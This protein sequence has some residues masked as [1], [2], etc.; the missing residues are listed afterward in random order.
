V[1]GSQPVS[2]VFGKEARV[3]AT[4][5]TNGDGPAAE[6]DD[7]DPVRVACLFTFVVVVASMDR[8]DS[9]GGHR[10]VRLLV[11]RVYHRAGL[12]GKSCTSVHRTPARSSG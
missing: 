10:V 12:S 2:G 7:L 4:V 5:V 11:C 9:A 6:V 8:V 1:G 3:S